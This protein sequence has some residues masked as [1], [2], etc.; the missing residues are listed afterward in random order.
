MANSGPQTGGSQFFI[1]TKN[2]DFLDFNK[3]PLQSKHPVFGKIVS[4]FDTV[5]KI[6]ESQNG[7]VIIKKAYIK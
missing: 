5:D 7:E 2:N 3:E 6:E 1:N 4:G